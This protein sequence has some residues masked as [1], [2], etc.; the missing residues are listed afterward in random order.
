MTTSSEIQS[1]SCNAPPVWS[2]RSNSTLPGLLSCALCNDLCILEV[3][4]HPGVV[5]VAYNKAPG[6]PHGNL[7]EVTNEAYIVSSES[8]VTSMEAF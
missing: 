8:R 7:R 6:N 5:L 4:R 3:Y 1:H 2:I